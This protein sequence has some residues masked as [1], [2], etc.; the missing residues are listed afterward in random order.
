M[1]RSPSAARWC[2][3]DPTVRTPAARSVHARFTPSDVPL[4]T[5]S[6]H[7]AMAIRAMARTLSTLGRGYLG[8]HAEITSDGVL[9]RG[10][11][12]AEATESQ[13]V[14][15]AVASALRGGRGSAWMLLPQRGDHGPRQLPDRNR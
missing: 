9:P 14:A 2:T 5:T 8:G 6:P 4:L 1:K 3:V 10:C 7:R 13:A 12:A 11:R 15:H